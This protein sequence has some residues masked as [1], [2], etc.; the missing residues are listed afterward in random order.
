MTVRQLNCTVCVVYWGDA[1]G[2]LALNVR[3]FLYD[4]A[5]C[6][7]ICRVCMSGLSLCISRDLCLCRKTN[8]LNQDYKIA[9]KTCN[10]I[11]FV[12]P[13]SVFLCNSYKHTQ[14]AGFGTLTPV[15]VEVVF[16]DTTPCGLVHDCW[17]FRGG[18]CFCLQDLSSQ[19]VTHWRIV[20]FKL[21]WTNKAPWYWVIFDKMYENIKVDSTQLKAHCFDSKFNIHI[22]KHCSAAK[23][24]P[25]D[26]ES[27][28]ST[29]LL[30][31]LFYVNH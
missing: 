23:F 19:I 13:C 29:Q 31:F 3:R 21:L 17:R 27:A 9:S 20:V 2:S 30:S 1:L 8:W 10:K 15:L 24:L 12:F 26:L 5:G 18:C 28:T 11:I 6:G 14:G 25:L 4:R 16:C 7:V 22:T